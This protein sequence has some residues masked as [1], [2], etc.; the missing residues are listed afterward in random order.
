MQYFYHIKDLAECTFSVFE[1]WDYVQPIHCDRRTLEIDLAL[2][3]LDKMNRCVSS[4]KNNH[5]MDSL[6]PFDCLIA[7]CKLRTD[8]EDLKSLISDFRILCTTQDPNKKHLSDKISALAKNI[9]QFSTK[10]LEK[11]PVEWNPAVFSNIGLIL[12]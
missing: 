7:V 6:N 12:N 4:T 8:L 9:D 3:N 5:Q 2:D 10:I 11:Y 1:A